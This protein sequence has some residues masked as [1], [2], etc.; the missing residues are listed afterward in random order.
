MSD[1]IENSVEGLRSEIESIRFCMFTTV[2]ENSSLSSRPMTRQ[3]LEDDATLWF[4]TS[5]NC[6]L[7]TDITAR[8]DVNVSFAE[9]SDG[10]YVSVT[11]DA[12]LV[13]DR[14]KFK[15]L[16]NPMVAAWYPL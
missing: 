5:D 15:Q 11:G 9:P 6:E 16:W 7:A 1:F 3:A 10:V 14:E 8:P 4:F 13:K 12:V 2:G